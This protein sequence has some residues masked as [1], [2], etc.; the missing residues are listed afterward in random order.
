VPKKTSRHLHQTRKAASPVEPD[1]YPSEWLRKHQHQAAG[2]EPDDAVAAAEAQPDAPKV[3]EPEFTP[4]P[5][6]KPANDT[7]SPSFVNPFINPRS[8]NWVP[9]ATGHVFD[10]VLDR[11]HSLRPSF[12]Q[13]NA[14]LGRAAEVDKKPNFIEFYEIS[15]SLHSD[16]RTN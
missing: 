4:E 2:E 8:P 9:D 6:P 11:A 5:A 10:A 7:S 15:R 12:S 16:K 1:I 13:T 14:S 3:P